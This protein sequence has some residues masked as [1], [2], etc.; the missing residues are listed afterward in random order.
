MS[1]NTNNAEEKGYKKLS[2]FGKEQ[3]LKIH[4]KSSKEGRTWSNKIRFEGSVDFLVY[5]FQRRVE[6]KD[7][8]FSLAAFVMHY[9]IDKHPFWDVSHRTAFEFSDV[10]LRTFGYRID[11]SRD[12]AIEFVR[13]IDSKKLSEKDVEKWLRKKAIKNID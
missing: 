8:V 10:V 2:R 13:S 6:R 4:E 7:D 12:E 3:I 9:V 5:E 1:E 11:T